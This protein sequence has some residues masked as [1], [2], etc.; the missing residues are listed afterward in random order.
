MTRRI[1]WFA[2]PFL[3]VAL[4]HLIAAAV[5]AQTLAAVTQALLMPTLAL[6][7]LAPHPDAAGNG[8]WPRTRLFALV[9]LFFSFLGDLLPRFFDGDL[10]FAVLIGCFFFAQLAWIAALYPRLRHS[11]VVVQRWRLVLYA[12][13]A[14][15]VLVLC[16]PAAGALAPLV[17][18]Y[19]VALTAMAILATGW[20]SFGTVGGLLF[21]VSDALIAIFTFRPEFDPGQPARSLLIMTTYIAAQFLLVLAVRQF[22]EKAR[23]PVVGRGIAGV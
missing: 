4:V 1:L 14:I 5:Q 10:S 18:V 19:A 20:G 8:W 9:A 7:L 15:I 22:S 2:L 3:A 21:L 23:Q 6:V 17:I 11:I 12:V 16:L 13:L